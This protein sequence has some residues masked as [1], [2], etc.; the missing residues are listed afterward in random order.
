MGQLGKQFLTAT[1]KV[2]ISVISWRLILIIGGEN[3]ITQRKPPTCRKA[4][5][6]FITLC[7][8]E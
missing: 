7:C 2:N 3:Q 8:I 6:N 1:A 4:L 5:T